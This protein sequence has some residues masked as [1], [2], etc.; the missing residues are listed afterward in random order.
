MSPAVFE[1][2]KGATFDA[3]HYFAEGP[4]HRPYS[5]LHGHSFRIALIS[6]RAEEFFDCFPLR[7]SSTTMMTALQGRRRPRTRE[8]RVRCSTNKRQ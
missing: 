2:T 3:A 4:E 5:R 8:D 6:G 1:I 7:F